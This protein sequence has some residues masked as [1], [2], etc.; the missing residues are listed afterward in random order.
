MTILGG[1]IFAI[2]A[3][4]SYYLDLKAEMSLE[5]NEL[6]D[7]EFIIEQTQ[8]IGIHELLIGIAGLFLAVFLAFPQLAAM[9]AILNDTFDGWILHFYTVAFVEYLEIFGILILYRF[10]SNS[11]QFKKI[12]GLRE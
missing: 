11:K 3:G 4:N 10:S 9:F 7:S 6:S 12:L 1:T 5:Y 8:K 2:E